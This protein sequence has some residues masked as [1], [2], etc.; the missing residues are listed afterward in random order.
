ML[1]QGKYF[2]GGFLVCVY[3]PFNVTDL[4]F[5]KWK[6]LLSNPWVITL[7]IKYGLKIWELA[8]KFSDFY[9]WP[10]ATF[11]Q[12]NIQ[13]IGHEH[14]STAYFIWL[15]YNFVYKPLQFA[16]FKDNV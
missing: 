15:T 11:P 12:T 9:L 5:S 3:S 7:Y 14:F 10:N 8:D 4:L 13:S 16:N 2:S 1:V 6:I